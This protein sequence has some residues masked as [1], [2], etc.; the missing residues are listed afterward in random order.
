M[1]AQSQ[2]S[3]G[4]FAYEMGRNV[5][6]DTDCDSQLVNYTT[7]TQIN[8]SNKAAGFTKYDPVTEGRCSVHRLEQVQTDWARC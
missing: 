2:A 6:F 1:F 7:H 8:G 4:S 3:V 5:R